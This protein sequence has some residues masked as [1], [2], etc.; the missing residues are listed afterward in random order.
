MHRYRHFLAGCVFTGAFMVLTLVFAFVLRWPGNVHFCVAIDHCYCEAIQW[1]APFRQPVNTWTNMLAVGIGL[2]LLWHGG[3][4]PNPPPATVENPM[5]R[6]G[7]YTVFYAY[8]VIMVG[9]G[10]VWFHGGMVD[11]GG[12]LDNVS[13]SMMV[14]FLI[15][16]D[17]GRL[18]DLRAATFTILMVVVNGVIFV[19]SFLPVVG[20]NTFTVLVLVLVPLEIAIL[21]WQR[22]RPGKARIHRDPWWFVL[23]L[24]TFLAATLAWELSKT[25]A[26]F[27][28][29]GSFWQGH[30][31]W[32]YLVAIALLF[33]Y[34]YLRSETRPR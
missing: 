16:Y 7:F 12:A 27:C 9:L 10:S 25:G 19:A 30:A 23:S 8:C 21:A 15:F 13:M 26:I 17:L 3:R 1:D 28:D 29:P 33:I 20:R 2:G 22:A 11:Y 32:H 31:A 34:K 6:E 4:M 24:G 5:Q 18:L 14:T